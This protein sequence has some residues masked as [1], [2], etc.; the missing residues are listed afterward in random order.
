MLVLFLR[1]V[2][3]GACACACAC[4]CGRGAPHNCNVTSTPRGPTPTEHTFILPTTHNTCSCKISININKQQTTNIRF[5][6]DPIRKPG[7]DAWVDCRYGNAFGTAIGQPNWNGQFCN[8]FFCS[9]THCSSC[10][11][12]YCTRCASSSVLFCRS[13]V[14]MSGRKQR[15][16]SPALVCLR[17][18]GGGWHTHILSRGSPPPLYG[19]SRMAHAHTVPWESSSTLGVS[20]APRVRIC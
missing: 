19:W 1:A 17:D 13:S 9:W 10:S 20:V 2:C 8:S 14:R 3:A 11:R 7:M 18:D 15:V 5:C 6:A 12:S 4:G 16:D